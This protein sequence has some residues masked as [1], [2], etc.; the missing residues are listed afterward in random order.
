VRGVLR[1]LDTTL[2]LNAVDTAPGSGLGVSIAD[3]R[4]RLSAGNPASVPAVEAGI[5]FSARLAL[6]REPVWDHCRQQ[7]RGAH[8]RYIPE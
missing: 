7:P 6:P 1:S 5:P 2:L 4:A 3:T 8:G